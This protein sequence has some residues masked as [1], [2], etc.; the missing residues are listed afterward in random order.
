DAAVEASKFQRQASRDAAG[1]T[2]EQLKKAGMQ[3]TELPPAEIAKLR[4]KMRP[5]IAKYSVSVGQ[6]TVKAMQDEL[7]KVRK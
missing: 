7:A 6:E 3:V 5:V 1:S 4:D 2:L